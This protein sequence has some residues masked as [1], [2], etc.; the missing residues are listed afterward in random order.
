MQATYDSIGTGY[1]STRKADP[2]ILQRLEELL[3]PQAGKLYL[4]I[5]CGTGNYTIAMAE[6]GYA[7]CGVDPSAQMLN[8]ARQKSAGV[9]WLQGNAEAIPI[10]DNTFDGA[11]ATLTIHHWKDLHRAFAELY[12]VLK[13][14]ARMV[15]FTSTPAQMKGY[16]LHEYFPKMMEACTMPMPA[17]N[18][19]EQAYTFVGFKSVVTEKY[20]VPTDLQDQFLYVG[21]HDPQMY[22][23]A[24]MRN[25]IS[26]FSL[27][28]DGM[29]V[30]QGLA[31]LKQDI[32]AG[33]FEAVKA[34]YK[35]DEGDYLFVVVEKI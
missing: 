5:G 28:A 4:D 32:D 33:N 17:L 22:F 21:K 6:K 25:G 16:W 15:I 29:E 3:H 13:S 9:Q 14:N 20:F 35:N 19:V 31:C 12:R 7:F 2:Y 24:Q 26:G 34:K 27:F 11:M 8:Q 1:N 23:N 18:T 10:A 30:E